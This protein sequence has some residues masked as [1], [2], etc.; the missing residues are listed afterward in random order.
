VVDCG[1]GRT[2][3][4]PAHGGSDLA[5]ESRAASAAPAK[6]SASASEWSRNDPPGRAQ[7][8]QN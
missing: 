3:R 1:E 2:R 5:T 6:N 8:G 7:A 4:A